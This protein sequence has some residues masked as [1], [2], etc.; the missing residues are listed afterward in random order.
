VRQVEALYR[1]P[2]EFR[3][4]IA[5]LAPSQR[6]PLTRLLTHRHVEA[7]RAGQACC[8]SLQRRPDDDAA[9][10]VCGGPL[11]AAGNDAE[12]TRSFDPAIT[13]IDLQPETLGREAVELLADSSNTSHRNGPAWSAPG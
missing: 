6:D 10:P 13:V 2:A 7:R 11:V 9:A 8:L 12:Q 5:D 1:G 4:A 3:A